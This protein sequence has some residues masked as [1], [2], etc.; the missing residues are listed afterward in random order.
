MQEMRNRM[1]LMCEIR[2][3]E[4]IREQEYSNNA[5]NEKGLA[6]MNDEV[7]SFIQEASDGEILRSIN[8]LLKSGNSAF[9]DSVNIDRY[10]LIGPSFRQ[11][12]KDTVDS[13]NIKAT[14][15]LNDSINLPDFSEERIFSI[16]QDDLDDANI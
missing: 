5:E 4:L 3:R 15:R 13:I 8:T 1:K 2:E 6:E 14:A 12:I 7:L 9:F 11:K 10:A 16:L